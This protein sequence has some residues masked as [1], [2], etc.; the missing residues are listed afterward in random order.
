[1]EE[2]GWCFGAGPRRPPAPL[3]ME[4][5]APGDGGSLFLR[6]R[7]RHVTIAIDTMACFRQV[8]TR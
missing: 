7:Y 8:P 3:P 1:M 6:Q 5:S 4:I 2:G